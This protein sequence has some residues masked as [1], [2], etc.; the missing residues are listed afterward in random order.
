MPAVITPN[1]AARLAADKANIIHLNIFIYKY[2]KKK[3]S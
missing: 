1:L 2:I 3:N